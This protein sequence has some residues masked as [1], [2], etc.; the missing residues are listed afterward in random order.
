MP[1]YLD[2]ATQ[3]DNDVRNK[4]QA[5]DY[6]PSESQ[7]AQRFNVNRHTVR[8]A[9]DELV[10]TGMVQ[11]HQGKGNMVLRQPH[12]YY[13]HAGAHFTGNLLEQ[14][15]LPRSEVLQARVIIANSKIAE[16]LN[17]PA[18]SKVIHIRTF[19]KIDGIPRTVIDH[20]LSDTTWWAVLKYFNTGS[21]HQF[22]NKELNI[23][24]QRKNTR[25]RAQIPTN[26]DCRLLQ[27]NSNIP[28]LK[29]KTTNVIKGTNIV[30][31]YSSSNT[32]SDVIELVMEH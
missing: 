12:D 6:L 10:A 27:I 7:L 4:Y 25:L 32:R 2:I 23:E 22:I 11:R 24:L 19:R 3:L 9:I 29:I 8:R 18:E 14:G 16:R 30:A 20:Y 31:E 5:G 1:V 15:S 17:K 26:E 21:L 28:I 13:L